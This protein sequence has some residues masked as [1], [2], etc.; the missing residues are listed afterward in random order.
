M[1]LEIPPHLWFV[2]FPVSLF[3]LIKGSDRFTGAA[4]KI[5]LMAGIPQ[6]IVGVVIVGIGT[7]L[8]ELISSVVAVLEGSSEIVAGNVIGSNVANI[9]L[10]LGIGAIVGKKLVI[11]YDLINV[12]LPLFVGS[13]LLVS[14]VMWDARIS[15]FDAVL[16]SGGLFIFMFYMIE[17]GRK[18]QA[19]EEKEVKPPFSIRPFLVI[20]ASAFIIFIG[21]KLT[22]DSVVNIASFFGVGNDIVAVSAV[23][24]GTSLPELG[25][26]VSAVGKNNAE[27]VVG[28][29]LGSNIFNS[30]AVPGITGIVSIAAPGAQEGLIVTPSII[31]TG[32]PAMVIASLLFLVTTQDKQV[33]RWE[34]MMFVLFYIYFLCK[35]INIL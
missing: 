4:E 13:A 6:F 16:L 17:S 14:F 12:D 32:I 30:F 10:I 9:F 3:V 31:T 7:S 15:F 19:E 1:G 18:P 29:I 5:G 26:T 25:V 21:A 20:L 2:I 35:V 8:P 33:S 28:N 23:A 27:M 34:G 22:V 11:K 24:L